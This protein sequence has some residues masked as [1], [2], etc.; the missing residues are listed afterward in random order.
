LIVCLEQNDP[1][2][3]LHYY[4]STATADSATTKTPQTMIIPNENDEVAEIPNDPNLYC[5][6][7][8]Q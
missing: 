3:K 8:I 4:D 5:Y 7:K 1:H 2:G 6:W